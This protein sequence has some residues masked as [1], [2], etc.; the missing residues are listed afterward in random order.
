MVGNREKAV[1]VGRKIYPDDVGFLVHHYVEEPGILV[2]GP[3]VVLAPHMGGEQVVQRGHRSPPWDLRGGFEPF[4]MLVEHGINIDRAD[5]ALL[6]ID[7]TEGV[8][9][10]DQRL[11]ER[12]DAAGSPV[13]MVLNK[14][15]CLGTDARQSVL[16]D[17]EDRL[18]FLGYA[19]VVKVSALTGLGVHTLHPT[20]NLAIEAYHRRIPTAELN[21]VIQAAQVAHAAPGAR[22]LYATQGAIDPPTFTLFAN[23]RLHPTYLRYIER[24]LR[25]HFEFG[26]TPLELRVRR[27]SSS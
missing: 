14:W 21:R 6:V 23:H 7:A 9:H 13:V 11:A 3:V 8:T 2:G 26:P 15:E 18:A 16:A 5:I 22:I 25:E 19:P 20:I 10:Q 12:I 4:G 1:G 17:V 24:R 27:R